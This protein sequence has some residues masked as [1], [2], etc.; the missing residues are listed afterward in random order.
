MINLRNKLLSFPN[1]KFLKFKEGGYFSLHFLMVLASDSQDVCSP[2]SDA[3][4]GSSLVHTRHNEFVLLLALLTTQIPSLTQ[5]PLLQKTV[6]DNLT[7]SIGKQKVVVPP[8][9]T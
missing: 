7:R 1:N 2:D 6:K 8:A 3:Q 5:S 9:L 4:I